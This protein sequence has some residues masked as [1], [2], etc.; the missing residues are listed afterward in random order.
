LGIP[1][2]T[3][4]IYHFSFCGLKKLKKSN[5]RGEGI[6]IPYAAPPAEDAKPKN[7]KIFGGRQNGKKIGKNPTGGERIEIPR[8][9]P[10]EDAPKN[11]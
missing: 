1:H 8:A 11:F 3:F 2:L 10:P 6:E 9:A 5:W 7:E 4:L